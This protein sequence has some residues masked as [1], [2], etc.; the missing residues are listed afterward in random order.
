[1]SNLYGVP[2]IS[3]QELVQKSQ[4]DDADFILLDVREQHELALASLGDWVTHVPLSELADKQQ[5]ALPEPI[6]NDKDVEMVVMCHHGH[7]SAQVT[8]WLLHHGW[9]QVW[10]LDGGIDAYAMTVD[11]GVGRY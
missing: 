3:P 7:R 1:M 2:G 5:E 10:N 4:Q 11:P 6:R 9:T 8:A